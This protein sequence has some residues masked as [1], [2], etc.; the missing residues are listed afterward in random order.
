M[1]VEKSET[2]EATEPTPDTDASVLA[3]RLDKWRRRAR[4]FHEAYREKDFETLALS[5]QKLQLEAYG[6]DK[7][8][9]MQNESLRKKLLATAQERNALKRQRDELLST[10]ELLYAEYTALRPDPNGRAFE[11]IQDAVRAARATEGET[12]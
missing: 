2:V 3:E 5:L 1:R 6:V 10:V 12:K 4:L 8:L 7:V 9:P 11:M